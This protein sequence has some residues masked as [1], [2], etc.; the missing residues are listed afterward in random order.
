MNM[1]NEHVQSRVKQRKETRR[2][3]LRAAAQL[4]HEQG[5][6]STTI[7]AIA[8][9]AGVSTGTVMAAGD[10]DQLL[11]A[12]VDERIE[13]LHQERALPQTGFLAMK[14]GNNAAGMITALVRPFLLIFAEDVEL[15]RHYAAVLARG[16][17][18]SKVFAE[19]AIR[20]KAEFEQVFK[21]FGLPAEQARAAAGTVHLAYLGTLFAWSSGGGEPEDV[22]A[23]LRGVVAVIMA[24]K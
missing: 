2:K 11:V 10:K 12:V 14:A 6:T 7:R 21:L 4:F 24:R 20:L 15:A 3:V 17:S 18:E 22:V 5:Y 19:L 13:L 23:Q 16:G 1:F 9:A 8:S